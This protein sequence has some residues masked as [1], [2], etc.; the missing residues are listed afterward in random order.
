MKSFLAGA[1]I[2]IVVILILGH[3][4][5]GRIDRAQLEKVAVSLRNNSIGDVGY[6]LLK[7]KCTEKFQRGAFLY[8]C[9]IEGRLL[10]V[11]QYRPGD[12][13]PIDDFEISLNN[14]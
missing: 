5:G 12:S 1:V 11:Q 6:T 3:K 2:V 8:D 13:K 10:M 7:E 14:Y 4:A 9:Q